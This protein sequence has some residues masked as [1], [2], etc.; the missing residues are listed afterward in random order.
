MALEGCIFIEHLKPAF[1]SGSCI[2]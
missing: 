1:I 2:A